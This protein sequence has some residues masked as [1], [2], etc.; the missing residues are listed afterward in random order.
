MNCP[1]VH[2]HQ[3]I[4]FDLSSNSVLRV[5]GGKVHKTG[6]GAFLIRSALVREGGGGFEG[7]D[8]DFLSAMYLPWRQYLHFWLLFVS[9]CIFFCLSLYIDF[10]LF[11][12]LLLPV[13]T[14]AG[15]WCEMAWTTVCNAPQWFSPVSFVD[16]RI[17]WSSSV[18]DRWFLSDDV[19]S[20]PQIITGWHR[21]SAVFCLCRRKYSKTRRRTSKGS[22]SSCA[23]HHRYFEFSWNNATTRPDP[24]PKPRVPQV[25]LSTTTP[26]WFVSSG[27]VDPIPSS[28]CRVTKVMGHF[29]FLET[30]EFRRLFCSTFELM[31]TGQLVSSIWP[32]RKKFKQRVLVLSMWRNRLDWIYADGSFSTSASR[33]IT[34]ATC[35]S[36]SRICSSLQGRQR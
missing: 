3:P 35:L 12:F 27:A 29:F 18:I 24:S 13:P 7:V 1:C 11:C 16:G 5:G 36:L 6:R 21:L 8:L 32:I 33:K 31:K 26:S 20:L 14:N 28:I 4:H 9:F 23:S 2:F 17:M 34:R 25:S 30:G 19:T 10:F 15:T 22:N